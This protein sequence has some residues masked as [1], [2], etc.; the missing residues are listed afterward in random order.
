MKVFLDTNVLLDFFVEGRPNS[1]MALEIFKSLRSDAI[2]GCTTAISIT[3]CLYVLEVSYKVTTGPD[4][5]LSVIDL[6]EVLPT[7]GVL[8]KN[9]LNSDFKD[10]ED[11]IQYFTAKHHQVDLIITNDIKGFAQSTIPVLTPY[12]FVKKH[13]KK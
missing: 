9:A 4:L 6:L 7:S 10:K 2:R 8:I 11:A 12:Q 5:I 3:D 1:F 13:L